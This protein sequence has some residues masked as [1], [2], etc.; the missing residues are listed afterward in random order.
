MTHARAD[1]FF[2]DDDTDDTDDPMIASPTIS[3]VL[4]EFLA[5]EENRLAPRTYAKYA[6]VIDLLKHSLN[7]YAYQTLDAEDSALFERLYDTSGN[8]EDREF[9]DI[10]GPGHILPNVG[11]FLDYFMVTKVMASQ[12]LL[13]AAG[14]VTKKLAKWLMERGY[15]SSNEAEIAVERGADAARDLPRAEKLTALLYDL[16]TNRHSPRD[17]DV[18][19]RFVITKVESGKVWLEDD[20]DGHAYGPITL[21]V[22]VTKLCQVGWT[23]SGTVRKS[24]KGW[25][26]VEAFKVY[27][28]G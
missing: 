19:G 26:L 28:W 24:G 15:A 10:F 1:A 23:I 20:D 16:T 21:P 2:F 17:S 7:G 14:T 12:D 5:T 11:E 3:E 27:P 13:R 22:K 6:D 25:A 8:G 4:A 18:E 9:C